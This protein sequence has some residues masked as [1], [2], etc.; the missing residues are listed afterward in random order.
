VNL[1]AE[2]R[3]GELQP[4]VPHMHGEFVS[5]GPGWGVGWVLKMDAILSGFPAIFMKRLTYVLYWYFAGGIPLAW[6]RTWE[7]FALYRQ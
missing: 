1:L 4:F 7:M 5:V 6:K 2:A 3:G